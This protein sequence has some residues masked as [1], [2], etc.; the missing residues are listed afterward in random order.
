MKVLPLSPI[1]NNFNGR[2]NATTF[3]MSLYIPRQ[4]KNLIDMHM[5]V[6][7]IDPIEWL[8]LCRALEKDAAHYEIVEKGNKT[9]FDTLTGVNKFIVTRHNDNEVQALEADP[10]NLLSVVQSLDYSVRNKVQ[11]EKQVIDSNITDTTSLITKQYP[12][13]KQ[14]GNKSKPIQ[15]L[16]SR[17]KDN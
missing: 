8:A 3:G 5:K 12:E 11:L 9:F 16:E 2:K 4:T 13:I 17:E 15:T 1:T 6:R 7:N 10:K 14:L